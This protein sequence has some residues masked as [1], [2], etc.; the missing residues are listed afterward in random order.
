MGATR[1]V[2]DSGVHLIPSDHQLLPCDA[3]IL[4]S[5]LVRRDL[6]NSLYYKIYLC[7]QTNAG[8][9]KF[10]VSNLWSPAV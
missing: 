8:L 7:L 5:S 4:D 10:G 3:H 2:V 9:L 6:F 1:R